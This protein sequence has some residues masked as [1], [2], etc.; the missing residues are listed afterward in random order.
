MHRG[1]T[2][3]YAKVCSSAVTDYYMHVYI[4][5]LFPLTAKINKF[6]SFIIL[7]Y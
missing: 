4:S 2:F 3:D 1:V 7:V 6:Y 5:V